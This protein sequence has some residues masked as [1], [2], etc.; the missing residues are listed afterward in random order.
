M[1]LDTLVTILAAIT[2]I[3]IGC[4]FFS[5]ATSSRN[6]RKRCCKDCYECSCDDSE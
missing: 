5:I 3:I 4:W 2:P 1:Q 6:E